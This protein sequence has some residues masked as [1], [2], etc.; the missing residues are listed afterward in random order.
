MSVAL[1][2]VDAHDGALPMKT[3]VLN[4]DGARRRR[5]L[6]GAEL[7]AGRYRLVFDVAAYFRARGVA[8]PDP[9]FLDRVTDRVRR[10]RRDRELPRAAA[11]V[12]VVV[13]HLSGQLMPTSPYL[14]DW[15]SLLLRWLH[16]VTAIAWIGTS[17][18]FVLT[19][20]RL[21]KPTDPDLLAKGVDGE[22]WAVHG[23]GFYHF[24]KYRVAPP[25]LPAQLHWS[26]WE[27]YATWMSG[28]ALLVGP[29]LRRTRRRSWSIRACTTGRR[30]RRS[31]ARSRTSSSA[32]SCT[33]RS[34]G[35]S[36]AT[37]RATSAA[38]RRSACWCSSTSASRPGSRAI[39]SPAARRSC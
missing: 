21:Y 23:G 2:R 9:P 30:P 20:D 29:V 16:V 13:R 37:R 5:S 33:T 10:R 11:R 8:L 4:D 36:A 12:A 39:C 25:S 14:L 17:F 31:P 27:T 6:D 26:Y 15:G 35:S 7:V 34:A 18:Y 3:V 38:T 19:D 24:E 32:G 22:S 1:L 28:F